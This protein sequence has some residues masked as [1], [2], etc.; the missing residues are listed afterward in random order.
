MQNSKVS[1]RPTVTSDASDR[2]LHALATLLTDRRVCVLTGAGLSTDSGIPDYRGPQTI[3]KKRNPVQYRPYVQCAETRRRY[4]A[5]SFIGWPRLASTRPNRAHEALH[6]LERRGLVCGIITQ[7]VDRLHHRAGSVGALEL[8][9]ALQ[10][11]VCLD[12]REV[13]DRGVLQA[14]LAALN[15]DFAAER[16]DSAPDGDAEL[17]DGRIRRFVAP[18]C[19]L[20]GGVLKP[21]VVFFGENVPRARVDRAWSLWQEAEVLLVVGS[22]L[23]VFSGYRFV[24]KAPTRD[25]PVAIVNL[26]PTRGDPIACLRLN[27]GVS[28]ILPA[29]AERLAA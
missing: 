16:V 3:H 18:G 27:R 11:V 5:R 8:H 1:P 22:S 19:D 28:E 17:D 20:C 21:N 14:R 9:G 10:E 15:P 25:L 4:W 13:S 24:K 6:R 7:N 29:L 2:E 26:G 12:C 23:T